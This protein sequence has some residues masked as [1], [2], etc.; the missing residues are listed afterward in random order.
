M[1]NIVHIQG[2]DSV[3][4][5]FSER[6]AFLQCRF[7][8]CPTRML[9]EISVRRSCF[10]RRCVNVVASRQAR[11]LR[12]T[13]G[14]LQQY[15]TKEAVHTFEIHRLRTFLTNRAIRHTMLET[16]AKW[17]LAAELCETHKR[18][19]YVTA[20]VLRR[21]SFK[22]TEVRF[23]MKWITHRMCRLRLCSIEKHVTVKRR[24]FHKRRYFREW[25]DVEWLKH[26]SSVLEQWYRMSIGQML[27]QVQRRAI[28]SL[29]DMWDRTTISG[30]KSMDISSHRELEFNH[31]SDRMRSVQFHPTAEQPSTSPKVKTSPSKKKSPRKSRSQTPPKKSRSQTPPKKT[32]RSVTNTLAEE[33]GGT[34]KIRVFASAVNRSHN[35]VAE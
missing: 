29:E 30:M 32:K 34:G 27:K 23:L 22:E 24:L 7:Q 11:L 25:K 2:T 12:R 9:T 4:Y 15:Y 33:G 3:G 26:F 13:F 14:G 16:F 1:D 6:L 19:L 21:K 31:D 20:K 8:D 35:I 28:Q 18:R 10:L 17:S 5:T